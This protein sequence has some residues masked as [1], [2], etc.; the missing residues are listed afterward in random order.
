MNKTLKNIYTICLI[1]SLA[2]SFAYLR[3]AQKPTSKP[4]I[5]V[6]HF[7]KKAPK[8]PI[9][10]VS[11]I[12]KAEKRVVK[13]KEVAKKI[14]KVVKKKI[15]FA[16]PL[17][18]EVKI[19]VVSITKPA[20]DVK[21]IELKRVAATDINV[22]NNK[23]L[24]E[25]YGY[26][27]NLNSLK[28]ISWS[29]YFDSKNVARNLASLN[30]GEGPTLEKQKQ[31]E[32]NKLA[33][34]K[35]EEIKRTNENL[36]DFVNTVASQKVDTLN[37]NTQEET[38]LVFYDYSK[39]ETEQEQNV[40]LANQIEIKESQPAKAK[41]E[42]A[43]I[44]K[45]N[46]EVKQEREPVVAAQAE[47]P[48]IISQNVLAAIEREM[49]GSLRV[50][51]APKVNTQ[52]RPQNEYSKVIDQISKKR[53]A[54]KKMNTQKSGY[55][56]TIVT[57]YEV[58]LGESSNEALRSFQIASASE[59]NN[60]IDD[61]NN[62]YI[63]I[64]AELASSQGIYRGTILK[65]GYLRT[66]MDI[67][68]EPGTIEVA[69]PS[70]T[71]D[72]MM[73]FLES[74]GING[75]GGFLL[76]DKD[77]GIQSLDIDSE[78]EAKFDLDENFKVTNDDSA[79]RYILFAGVN[80][81]NTLLKVRTVDNEYSEKIIHIVEDEL[82]FEAL[83]INTS[84]KMEVITLER[85]ILSNRASELDIDASKIKYFNRDIVATKKA[86]NLHE[87]KVPILPLG[88][89]KYL[90]FRHLE[91]TIYVGIGDNSEVE[92][93]SS[94]F[95]VN[96]L[97]ANNMSG[98]E[99]RC[100]IQI[101]MNKPLLKVESIGESSRGPMSLDKFYLEKNGSLSE[102]ETPLSTK[103]FILGDQQGIIIILWITFK[104]SVRKRLIY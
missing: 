66:S 38:D 71:Q 63:N 62:G 67:A 97:E 70:I 14:N 68:L 5:F 46:P 80:A 79:V 3:D 23:E 41:V 75:L 17:N 15:S 11:A 19:Q 61:S 99:G 89:R 81:G 50:A 58:N 88:M 102:E 57:T 53:S 60:R 47:T 2:A 52:P 39:S 90:E 43:V 100:V 40:E 55:S 85:A 95:I 104:H 26:D 6:S 101:N 48:K 91:D 12:D 36:E 84:E 76:V 10:V 69:I 35:K 45:E 74:Q 37:V 8:Q 30:E 56:K 25:H 92:L 29:N 82:L 1:A 27:V 49:G 87:I 22:V 33:E 94:D 86:S 20:L 24:I 96:L 4:F 65:R 21:E 13:K 32:E 28:T 51:A 34:I 31:V 93:P 78:F 83:L 7:S 64:E 98:M 9:E 42:V 54:A 77:R 44:N 73:K 16:K 59:G 18:K 72:S 103:I